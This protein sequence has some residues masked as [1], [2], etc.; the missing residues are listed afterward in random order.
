MARVF[1][2]VTRFPQRAA[3]PADRMAGFM[4]HLRLNGL[5][6][7]VEETGKAL[8]ALSTVQ[9]TEVTEARMALKAVLTS[10]A[11]DFARFDDLF[12]AY[13]NNPGRERAGQAQT[14]SGSGAKGVQALEAERAT[15][16]GKADRPDGD[17][18]GEAEQSGEGRRIGSRVTNILSVDLRHVLDP[19]D[20]AEAEAVAARLARAIRDRRSRRLK[21]DQRGERM[22]MRRILRASLSTGG[23]PIRL[24]R[25]A[26]PE[27]P[28]RLVV[29]LDVS[30]SMT[31]YAPVF[32]AF[33]KGLMTADASTDAYL[34]H[35][36]LV[37]ITDAL[38][39]P[40]SLRAVNRLSL[41]AQG[42]GGGTRIG[43][44]LSAFN[45][46]YGKRLVSGRSL[47]MILSD[48]FD[49]DPPE[50]VAQE[51]ARLK[52][53]GCRIIW[54]NPMKGWRDYQPVAAGM[55]AALPHLDLFAAANTLQ[56]LAALE[57]D[58]AR[59]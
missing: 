54:L 36:R 42:F 19:A 15:G 46:S 26:R 56:S 12:T 44:N 48:G 47:V 34:F 22:D 52:K 24:Y 45:Q 58:L 27:R 51:L 18:K 2:P 59:I 33:V 32:L 57:P 29:L 5:K 13:W 11:D 31:V 7:G 3:G 37:R 35:T 10:S 41:L 21:A 53:R 25:R 49:T 23:E 16:A 6:V 14:T 1:K 38:R 17:T 4:A 20:R 39:D 30:G 43:G 50:V 55:A 28:A 40:D 8:A 9:A